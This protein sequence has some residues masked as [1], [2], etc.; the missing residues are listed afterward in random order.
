[1]LAMEVVTFGLPTHF[2]SKLKCTHFA[3]IRECVLFCIYFDCAP[4]LA[5]FSFFA[6]SCHT[7]LKRFHLSC[8]KIPVKCKK[9]E[10]NRCKLCKYFDTF[11]TCI[12]VFNFFFSALQDFHEV[13]AMNVV[14]RVRR[15]LSLCYL[16]RGTVRSNVLDRISC[17]FHEHVF[18]PSDSIFIRLCFSPALETTTC[19]VRH[20]KE[21]SYSCDNI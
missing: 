14:P 16:E 17:K 13:H 8:G 7:H 20:L 3:F 15:A 11:F 4:F 19:N 6:R 10:R 21:T 2:V 9:R 1:M 18:I 12:I 5:T